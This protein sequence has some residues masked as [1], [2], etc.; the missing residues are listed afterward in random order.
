MYHFPLS[1]I[2]D[3]LDAVNHIANLS[4]HNVKDL[5]MVSGASLSGLSSQL[6][7]EGI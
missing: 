5:A 2:V 6:G 1:G 4:D 7:L 3:C